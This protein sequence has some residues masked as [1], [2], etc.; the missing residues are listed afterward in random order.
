MSAQNYFYQLGQIVTSFSIKIIYSFW[1][2]LTL[3]TFFNTKYPYDFT[4]ILSAWFVMTLIFAYI[5]N[6]SK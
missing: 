3:N 5:N 2:I 4:H 6:R 1:L